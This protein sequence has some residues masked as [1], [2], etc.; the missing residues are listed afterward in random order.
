MGKHH[1]NNIGWFRLLI[2]SVAGVLLWQLTPPSGLS[3]A[4]W[5]SATIFV[6]TIM[7]IVLKILPLGAIGFI[8]ITLFSLTNAAGGA[9]PAAA[10]KIA[11]GEFSS[12]LLWL[13]VVAFLI[14]R[15]FIKTGL[16][17]RIALILVSL[18]GK[19]TL[20]LA[21]SLAATDLILAPAMPSNVARCGGVIYPI[22]AA[23]ARNFDSNPEDSSRNKIGTFLITCVS[24]V[25]DITSTM[26]M[27][28]YAGNLIAVKLAADAGIQLS[29]GKWVLASSVP[30]L[31]CLLLVPLIAYWLTNPEIKQTPNAPLLA[32]TELQQMGSMSRNEKRMLGTFLLLLSLWIFGGRLGIDATQ[33]AFIGL[34]LLLLSGVLTWDEVK[35]EQGAWDTLIWFSALLMMAN[36][37]KTLGFTT[38]LGQYIG[39]A[40]SHWMVGVH[41]IWVL[42]VLNTT[43]FYIHYF[44]AS[45]NAQIAA[46]FSVFLVMGIQLGIP[47]L[48]AT[49][50]LA[51]TSGLFC[52]I[53]QYASA[54]GPILFGSGFVP[55]GL[56]W[57]VGFVISLIHQAVFMTIGLLWWKLLGY[58]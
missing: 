35:G 38:W 27:T 41:W 34:T 28:A 11:L 10:M 12:P 23:L 30:C 16:G 15:G 57:R 40:I 55:T 7:A 14:A 54:R 17:R 20:G 1:T 22:A 47:A 9:S 3:T 19:R 24:N 50:M 52:S 26:F 2:L 56:W 45:G 4:A 53:T 49:L 32:R 21:Y 48:P 44:F 33:T 37:I 18:F 43:Y 36:L 29:W 46:L 42:L 6:A 39:N 8:S 58:Y 5:H 13:V 31:I 51:F 25:N